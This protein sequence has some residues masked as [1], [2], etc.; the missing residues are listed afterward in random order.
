V[1]ALSLLAAVA[2][3]AVF[4]VS[5][6]V[7]LVN[8]HGVPRVGVVARLLAPVELVIATALVVPASR[9]AGFIGALLLLAG[10]T[11]A[12]AVAMRAGNA[13]GSVRTAL[14]NTV[15]AALS[16]VGLLAGGGSATDLGA[17]QTVAAVL[18]GVV[19]AGAIIGVDRVAGRADRRR[20]APGP[21]LTPD[22]ARG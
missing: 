17:G 7:R 9:A 11:R 1:S 20:N 13:D 4:V 12:V 3:A 8:L 5:A 14:R 22:H 18:G 21:A 15:L 2:L 16:G 10:L 19:L 6:I